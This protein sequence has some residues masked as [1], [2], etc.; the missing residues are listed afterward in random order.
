MAAQALRPPMLAAAVLPEPGP[1]AGAATARH[2]PDRIGSRRERG[3]RGA[4]PSPYRRG[5]RPYGGRSAFGWPLPATNHGSVG[6]TN[7][8]PP[9][10]RISTS[11]S[12][13]SA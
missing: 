11:S 12:A 4:S 13:G 5:L 10:W 9:L 8:G 3:Q 6:E 2:R 1:V 7:G